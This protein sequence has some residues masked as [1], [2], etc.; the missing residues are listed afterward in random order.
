MNRPNSSSP[1][2]RAPD[3]HRD[4]VVNPA[5]LR[6]DAP[7]LIGDEHDGSLD[8]TLRAALRDRSEPLVPSNLAAR[9][10]DLA[11]ARGAALARARS[12]QLIRLRK[13]ARITAVAA[14]LLIAACAAGAYGY[15]LRHG[16]LE[17][18]AYVASTTTSDAAS[19]NDGSSDAQ[20]DATTSVS[21]Q[22]AAA[23]STS[24]SASDATST[25]VMA[26]LAEGLALMLVFTALPRGGAAFLLGAETAGGLW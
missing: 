20:K 13:W 19:A 14:T 21:T 18:L 10:I 25:V 23:E 26:L 11:R 7:R 2:D 24:T 9:A 3:R 6:P 12:E 4:Q 15:L 16:N 8:A 22:N 5:G 17:A 1:N